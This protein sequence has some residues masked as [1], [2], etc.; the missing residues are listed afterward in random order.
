VK[1]RPAADE[2]KLYAKEVI[3]SDALARQLLSYC[4]DTKVEQGVKLSIDWLRY[5]GEI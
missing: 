1:G 5:L 4:P 2:L 3:Y